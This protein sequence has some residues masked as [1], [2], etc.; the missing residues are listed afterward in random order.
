M[1]R[2]AWVRALLAHAGREARV[3]LCMFAGDEAIQEAM[4]TGVKAVIVD[5][6][7]VP[8][9]S[10]KVFTA[11][12]FKEVSA[13]AN[14]VVIPG[15]DPAKLKKELEPH[16]N[17]MELWDDKTI[18][19]SSAGADIMCKR[20]VY[21][22]DKTFADGFGWVSANFIPHW[23]AETWPGWTDKDWA[24]AAKELSGRPGG[25]PLF[26]VREGEFVE[27]AVQ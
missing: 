10:F 14:V 7:A 6:A 25:I 12:N 9:V 8:D 22:Q 13:W 26:T 11:E 16:G 24:W 17:L 20:Y 19:G 18:S 23:Q 27:I 3:A 1:E 4:A 21:L 2:A 15:G 5:A